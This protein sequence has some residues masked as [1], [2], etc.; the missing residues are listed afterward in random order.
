MKIKNLSLSCLE[1]NKYFAV[2]LKINIGLY[3]MYKKILFIILIDFLNQILLL[4]RHWFHSYLIS[5]LILLFKG[6]K[7]QDFLI[8]LFHENKIFSNISFSG[9]YNIWKLLHIS[10][11][12]VYFQNGKYRF[13][14][15]RE[16]HTTQKICPSTRHAF[17]NFWGL[18]LNSSSSDAFTSLIFDL[19]CL[20][21]GA[22]NTSSLA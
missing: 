11:L 4:W 7:F 5:I 8:F 17:K 14:N 21:P 2:Y 20:S 10:F 3:I 18:D 1:P 9:F 13:N 6:L 15:Q 12:N 22:Q 19:H 16:P